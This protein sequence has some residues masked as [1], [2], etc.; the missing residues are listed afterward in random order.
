MP[1]E[2]LLETT[3]KNVP[4]FLL[5]G[6]NTSVI[7]FLLQAYEKDFKIAHIANGTSD[8]TSNTYYRILPESSYLIDKLE[9]KIDY[10]VISL[11]E[12]KDKVILQSILPKLER[13]QTKTLIL[14]PLEKRNEFYDIIL[15]LKKN[16]FI[17][18]GFLADI[19]GQKISLS[20]SNIS[21]IIQNAIL[22]NAVS[23][24]EDTASSEFCIS[25]NDFLTGINH[26]LFSHESNKQ[27]FYLLYEH[28]QTYT[29]II[30]LLSR[31]Q[32]GLAVD[33][34]SSEIARSEKSFSQIENEVESKTL[35]KPTFLD[36]YYLGFE[37]SVRLIASS[38]SPIELYFENKIIH[39][40]KKHKKHLEVRMPWKQSVL[41]AIL[42]FIFIHIISAGLGYYSFTKAKSAF[43]KKDFTQAQKF[44]NESLFFI[45]PIYPTTKLIAGATS[46]LSGDTSGKGVGFLNSS[47]DIFRTT[48]TII[49]D[50]SSAKNGISEKLLTDIVSSATY[51]FFE[52]QNMRTGSTLTIPDLFAQKEYTK[53]LTTSGTLHQILGFDK[54]KKY[55]LLFQ[56]NGELRP[57]G[58]FIGS[59]GE[60]TISKG[61]I[62]D[63]HINDVYDVD[64][65]LKAHVEPHYVIRRYLQPHLY[66][67]DSNFAI[68]FE[69]SASTSALI[70]NLALQKKVDGVVGISFEAVRQII[71]ALGPITLANYN[72][73]LD[74]NNTFDF[75]QNEIEANNFPG[76]SKKKELL[77]ALFN[78]LSLKLEQDKNSFYK[79]FY[80]FPELVSSK[81]ILFAFNT[82]SIQKIFSVNGFSGSLFDP[83]DKTTENI[84]D[85]FST[86]EANIGANKANISVDRH[87]EYDV[88]L[89]KDSITSKA[90]LILTNAKNS[91]PSYKTYVRFVVPLG[92]T[93]KTITINGEQQTLTS[94]IT[95][96][97][98]Y[99]A[100]RFVAPK[101]L[102]IDTARV[103]DLTSFGFITTVLPGTTQ[104]IEAEYEN[105]VSNNSSGL[106]NYSLFF[107]KQPGTAP[108]PLTVRLHYS[109][110]FTPQKVENATLNKNTITIQES[111][112]SDKEI[113]MSF[114]K[115]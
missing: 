33:F 22:K 14:I 17:K 78:N 38:K 59:I 55:L 30:H 89:L 47:F 68:N 107:V 60:I 98:I 101:G 41:I 50:V 6:N 102:E 95:D 20:N 96:Y 77:Q 42:L 81:N 104:K 56:N 99:E 91:G 16:K 15:E 83:R 34:T 80:L 35:I 105:A 72:I 109:D 70:Y 57:T 2:L 45:S 12:E 93:L 113:K 85:I 49:S 52:L 9:D 53:L 7:S 64:G 58:G 62:T 21:K 3:T 92:S 115:R 18:F 84:Y 54:E 44:S 39:E 25:D 66:L 97:R 48:T 100:T 31:V 37:K 87:I 75:L 88:F 106:F 8:K 73:T 67:R 114:I 26:I 65:Q 19:F 24:P 13:D 4:V 69:D 1:K 86:N 76:T 27:F 43:N 111:I 51:L 11:E 74:E 63:F 5:C 28:P 112:S 46:L 61:K 71:K 90:T 10:A 23:L 82:S 110:E 36:K 108:H 103:D 79:I 32:P 29:S 94:A 40:E